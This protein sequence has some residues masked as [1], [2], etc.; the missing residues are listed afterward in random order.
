MHG[1]LFAALLDELRLYP[2]C[3]GYGVRRDETIAKGGKRTSGVVT[4]EARRIPG[5]VYDFYVVQHSSWAGVAASEPI[6]SNAGNLVH[7][8]HSSLCLGHVTIYAT[9]LANVKSAQCPSNVRLRPLGAILVHRLLS[10]TDL[11]RL[12][13]HRTVQA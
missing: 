3:C 7:P 10:S 9:V 2:A 5:G 6:I 13:T 1:P 8:L 4:G 12:R 11:R